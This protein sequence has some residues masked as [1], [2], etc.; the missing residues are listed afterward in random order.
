MLNLG[1]LIYKLGEPNDVYQLCIIRSQP[2]QHTLVLF[3]P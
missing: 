2:G 3:N 1:I